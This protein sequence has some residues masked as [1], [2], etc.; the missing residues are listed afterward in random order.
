MFLHSFFKLTLGIVAVA[1]MR[2]VIYNLLAIR[3][4]QFFPCVLCVQ[5]RRV[6]GDISY[7]FLHDLN[8]N[9][10]SSYFFKIISIKFNDIISLFIENCLFKYTL[11]NVFV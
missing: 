9:N 7:S 6:P 1:A 8:Q 4:E 5:K 10:L 2:E 3:K 11:I